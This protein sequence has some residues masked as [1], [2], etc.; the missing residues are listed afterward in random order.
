[1]GIPE[2]AGRL[3]IPGSRSRSHR[4]RDAEFHQRWASAHHPALSNGRARV[5][6]GQDTALL[7]PLPVHI[8]VV[9][10]RADGAS[11]RHE[12]GDVGT[13]GAGRRPRADRAGGARRRDR[14]SGRGHGPSRPAARDVSGTHSDV[15]PST[16]HRR[17]R[18]MARVDT[19]LRSGFVGARRQPLRGR[20]DD[21]CRDFRQRR[22]RADGAARRPG[23]RQLPEHES[24][25]RQPACGRDRPRRAERR[26]MWR[27]F[28]IWRPSSANSGA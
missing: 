23:R 27:S 20:C 15:E 13:D 12:H 4:R 26:T 11:N 7:R 17:R 10:R 5:W 25:G 3:A 2:R 19:P 6:H 18:R 16:V 8:R 1:M 22:S 14:A 28:P 24:S 9:R 21:G